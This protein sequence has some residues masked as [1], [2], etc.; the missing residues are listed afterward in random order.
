MS[1]TPRTDEVKMA[2]SEFMGFDHSLAASDASFQR[3][4]DKEFHGSDE[5][6]SAKLSE[7]L[8]DLTGGALSKTNYPVRTMIQ[9]VEQYFQECYEAERA[10]ELKELN[11]MRTRLEWCRAELVRVR[12]E[13]VQP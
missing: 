2:W 3:W 12:Q 11:D 9:Q 1:Y 8:C 6:V 4:Y 7:L 5:D 13:R 10:V